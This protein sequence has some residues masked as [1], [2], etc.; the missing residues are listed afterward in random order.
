MALPEDKQC[1]IIL[2]DAL[3]NFDDERCRY[4]IKVLKDISK[5]RQVILFS[6]HSR[7]AEMAKNLKSV[8]ITSLGGTR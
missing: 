1:P 6:C 2:D 7:E 3:V 4:A 8:K 5:K